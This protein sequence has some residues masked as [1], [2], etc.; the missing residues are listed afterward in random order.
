[1]TMT[2][3][4]AGPVRYPRR[5]TTLPSEAAAAPTARRLVREACAAWGMSRDVA[6]T[7][8]LLISEIVTNA[9]RHGRSHHVRVSVEQPCPERLRVAVVD[10]S[11]RGPELR[12]VGPDATGGRGLFLV[13][14]LSDRWGTDLLPWGKRV[15]AET[16]SVA[17]QEADGRTGPGGARDKGSVGDSD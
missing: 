10:K 3:G 16:G 6:E 4:R 5:S 1:M 17:P 13:D 12:R 11:G 8:A 14:A 9:V 15:W 2:N 7:G